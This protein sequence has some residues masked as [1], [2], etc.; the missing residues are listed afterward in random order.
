MRTAAKA[1]VDVAGLAMNTAHA[2]DRGYFT[3]L[4]KD[5]SAPDSMG[6]EMQQRIISRR[7]EAY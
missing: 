3:L 6:E 1:G 2:G 7:S 5:A 4:Q